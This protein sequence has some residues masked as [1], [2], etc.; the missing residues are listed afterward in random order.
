VEAALAALAANTTPATRYEAEYGTDPTRWPGSCHPVR[1]HNTTSTA[2][3]AANPSAN[4][5]APSPGT[6]RTNTAITAT[7][8]ICR[9]VNTRTLTSFVPCRSW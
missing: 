3:F 2:V 1:N 9:K 7:A 6:S 5:E 8:S 4:P